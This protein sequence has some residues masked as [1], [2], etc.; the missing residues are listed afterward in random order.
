MGNCFG[1]SAPSGIYLSSDSRQVPPSKPGEI[2][3]LCMNIQSNG[4]AETKR[5]DHLSRLCIELDA[6]FILCQEPWKRC[7][8]ILH[9]KLKNEYDYHEA[10]QG[11][12]DP[13]K[14]SMQPIY[15]RRKKFIIEEK[16]VIWLSETPDVH[17]SKS[18][19]SA[20]IRTATWVVVRHRSGSGL[21]YLL[22]NIHLDH[23]STLAMIKQAHVCYERAEQLAKQFNCIPII[24]GDFNSA[25]GSGGRQLDKG[26]IGFLI[27]SGNAAQQLCRFRHIGVA[28]PELQIAPNVTTFPGWK[29]E[30]ENRQHQGCIA[31]DGIFAD[32]EID[33]KV[34]SSGI[35]SGDSYGIRLSDHRPV[36]AILESRHEFANASR[37]W[38]EE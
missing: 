11:N 3:I 23:R 25:V 34:I 33:F 36:Y 4:K 26:K 9:S 20:C 6:D 1:I 31:I 8:K 32:C 37:H 22:I 29:H 16:G 14:E 18:W 13:E 12:D 19:G 27:P 5:I 10:H 30:Y 7:T 21:G 17:A 24:A 2:R 38:E 15:V 35:L 28:A